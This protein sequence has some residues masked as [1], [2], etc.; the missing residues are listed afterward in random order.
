[1]HPKSV[2]CSAMGKMGDSN[3]L[4][5]VPSSPLVEP[6]ISL[7]DFSLTLHGLAERI[8]SSVLSA[9]IGLDRV[10]DMAQSNSFSLGY[11][12]ACSVM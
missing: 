4:F 10:P 6:Q 1:M 9:F 12:R 3:R 7:F 5:W 8:E 2:E 11:K